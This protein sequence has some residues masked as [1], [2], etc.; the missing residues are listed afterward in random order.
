VRIDLSRDGG[1]TWSTIV[2]ST[3]D[4]GSQTWKAKRP[5]TI[6]AKIRVCSINAPSVCGVSPAFKIQ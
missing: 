3:P 5:Q 4:D 2:S 6:Q 1:A